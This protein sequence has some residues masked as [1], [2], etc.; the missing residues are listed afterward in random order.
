ML[1]HVGT[2]NSLMEDGDLLVR[3]PSNT[4]LPVNPQAA[5]KVYVCMHTCIYNHVTMQGQH[6]YVIVTCTTHFSNNK[7]FMCVH[8]DD[9]M[10]LEVT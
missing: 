6:P 3:Y 1:D 8:K 5:K 10:T 9:A 2:V 7:C 4:L